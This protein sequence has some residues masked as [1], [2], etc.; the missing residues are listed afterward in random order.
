MLQKRQCKFTQEVT[1]VI[2]NGSQVEIHYTLTVD[3]RVVDSSDGREPL[4]YVH[5]EQQIIPGLEEQLEG[6]NAG[7]K[8][9][10][11]VAPERGYGAWDPN[12]VHKVPRSAFKSPDNVKVGDVVSGQSGDNRFQAQVTEVGSAEITLDLNHPL[13]GKTLHFEVEVVNVS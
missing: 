4:A 1:T 7:D 10:V 6:L 3:D 12:G 11:S 5:G 8:K 13:A 9:A 2:Q